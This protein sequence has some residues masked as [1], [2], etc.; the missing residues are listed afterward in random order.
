MKDD[1]DLLLGNFTGIRWGRGSGKR[2]EEVRINVDF[3]CS[4][5]AVGRGKGSG[6]AQFRI[7]SIAAHGRRSDGLT[8]IIDV[9]IRPDFSETQ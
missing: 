5:K 7:L 3:H 6:P 1:L 8:K 4:I 2:M 9:Q